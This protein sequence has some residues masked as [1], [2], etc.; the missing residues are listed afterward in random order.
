MPHDDITI[1]GGGPVGIW[2]LYHTS[3]RQVKARLIESLPE[4]GGQLSAMYPEK[5]I[6]DV[7]GFPRVMARDLVDSLVAQ[8]VKGT[9]EV[10]L[11]E[12]V[13]GLHPDG[14]SWRILTTREEHVAKAVVIATGLGAFNPKKIGL[15]EEETFLGK[16][17]SYFVRRV[18]DLDGKKIVVVGGGDSAL[19]W[20]NTFK[21]KS[22]VTLVHRLER[23]QAHEASVREME[24]SRKVSV[25]RPWEVVE[26]RGKD[27]M[28]SVR[29]RDVKTGDEQIV[30]ADELLICIG[31]NAD[32]GP[33]KNWG[34]QLQGGKI[35]V[36]REMRTNLPGVFAAGD[37]VT[38]PGKL[39]LIALGFGEV[40]IAVKSAV[41][42]AF[43]G[44]RHGLAHSSS[45]GF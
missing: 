24:E 37:A 35:K 15:L 4:L 13:L 9:S 17:V 34:L 14:S 1:L 22:Q 5:P 40:A 43:P 27:Q 25:Y 21:E 10:S 16:G 44:E 38:Y 26:I 11:G 28:E 18:Q 32:L 3:L 20:V 33:I 45:R 39:N 23:F 29:L 41:D 30:E 2:G 8:S 6:F 36:D 19:D 31:F 42:H 7:G 12:K